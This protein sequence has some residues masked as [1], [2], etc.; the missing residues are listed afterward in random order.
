MDPKDYEVRLEN[1]LIEEFKKTFFD[2][3]D[4][5]PIVITKNRNLIPNMS[6]E[7]LRNL[8]LPFAPNL[9]SYD[10]NRHV[11]DMRM[12]FC[13]LARGMRYSLK[14]IGSYI[15]GRDHT[16]VRYN[17]ISF[18]NIID[19]NEDFRHKFLEVIES[20]KQKLENGE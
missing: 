13:F 17:V 19:T 12:I 14:E 1:K 5:H 20:I 7:K 4:Y 2:K 10:T 9:C 3:F 11:V 8:I 18:N 15:G 6:L 16:T